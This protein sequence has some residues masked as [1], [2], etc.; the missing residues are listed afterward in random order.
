VVVRAAVKAAARPSP[1][2]EQLPEKLRGDPNVAKYESLDA[3]V[4]GHLNA[5]KR[6]GVKPER[7]LTL[8]EKLD[9]AKAMAEVYAK[10]GRPDTPD[11]YGLKV[12]DDATDEVKATATE[13]AG[14]FHG[15]GLEAPPRPQRLIDMM[16]EKGGRA[17]RRGGGRRGQAGGGRLQGRRSKRTGATSSRPIHGEIDALVV[18][19][20]AK[21]G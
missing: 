12:A 18:E 2:L 13:L 3:L 20:S 11:G 8:P 9:D 14:E 17:G 15:M 16:S 1:W 19:L 7:L 4:Q 5:V 6:M 10:L 21:M